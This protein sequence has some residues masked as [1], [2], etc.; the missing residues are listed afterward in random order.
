M[1][2]TGIR[3]LLIALMLLEGAGGAIACT[4]AVIGRSA[5][6]DNR[7]LLWKNRDVS[8][9]DQQ[10]NYFQPVIRNGRQL[11]GYT[12]NYYRSDSTRIYMGANDA[13]F[14]IINSNTYNLG[15]SLLAG[16]D[17]GTLM[18]LALESCVKMADFERL[19][20]STDVTGRIDCWN[21]G[22]LDVNGR[23]AIYECANHYWVA[24]YATTDTPII[25]RS[26]FSMCGG[27]Y[28]PGDIRYKRA[29]QLLSDLPKSLGVTPSFLLNNLSRDIAN[30]Y[31]NPLPLPYNRSQNGAPEGYVSVRNSLNN[32]Y[33]LSA[34]VIRGIA[35]YENPQLTLIYATLGYPVMSLAFP[36][37]VG[38]FSVPIYLNSDTIA[39]IV[40]IVTARMSQFF[41]N[42]QWPAYGNSRFLLDNYGNG[43]YSYTLPAERAAIIF[44]DSCQAAWDLSP[45]T[46]TEISVAQWQVANRLFNSFRSGTAIWI[47]RPRDQ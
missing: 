6:S 11:H 14:A 16:I 22:V 42:S 20:D 28:H 47:M 15:D 26:N 36:L 43:A 41:D 25:V 4:I 38:S 40:N 33:S 32:A 5:T 10:F 24:Y 18:R 3:F 7:P 45:P 17:D 37:W 23:A 1:K 2:A 19:L 27:E 39:P 31:D 13:G 46:S 35:P 29:S 8:Y 44:A 9:I 30:E 34:V 12:G 21:F